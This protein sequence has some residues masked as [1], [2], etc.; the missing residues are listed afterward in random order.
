MRFGFAL[1]MQIFQ[2]AITADKK[3]A[4]AMKGC[5]GCGSEVVLHRHGRYC[6]YA[7]AGGDALVQ[8]QRFICP[9]CGRTTSVI[10]EGMFPYRSVPVE[11][12]QQHMDARC[13][14][15]AA[16]EGSGPPPA[17]EVEQGCIRRNVKKL[18]ERKELI[19]GF[20]GQLMPAQS[21]ADLGCF[22]RAL[23]KLGSTAEILVRLARDFKSSL[24]GCYR[25]LRPNCGRAGVPV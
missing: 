5:G 9:R 14:D 1:R 23:R 22:W 19:C 7:R 2:R 13:G 25:T 3:G 16:G 24:F 11:K 17:S 18:L 12:F 15:P 20:L 6:R 8:V 21:S 4:L 10:P